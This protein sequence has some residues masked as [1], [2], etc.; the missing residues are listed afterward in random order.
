[1]I[2][3]IWVNDISVL[4]DKNHI[5]EFIPTDHM[6]FNQ[7]INTIVR[8]SFYLSVL[9]CLVKQTFKYLYIFI[10]TLIGTFI[11]YSTTNNNNITETFD[12]FAELSEL[13]EEKIESPIEIYPKISQTILDT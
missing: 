11:I 13:T 6:T 8:F 3:K 10:L 4:L 7:K 9:L 5:L 1:M 2:T 12:S